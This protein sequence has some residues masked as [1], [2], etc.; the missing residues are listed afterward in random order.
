MPAFPTLV[1]T[2][3]ILDQG[4]TGDAARVLLYEHDIAHFRACGPLGIFCW[5]WDWVCL[6][7]APQPHLDA[8]PMFLPSSSFP[9]ELA[10]AHTIRMSPCY[11]SVEAQNKR[12]TSRPQVSPRA[13]TKKAAGLPRVGITRQK[14]LEG[15]RRAGLQTPSP[16]SVQV[17]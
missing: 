4:L 9:S 17:A 15:V 5:S 6:P 11:R 8:R 1:L 13:P 7:W 16:A 10:G 12:V 3:R 14:S 2:G